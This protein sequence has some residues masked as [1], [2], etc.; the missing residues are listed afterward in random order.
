MN[1]QHER[2]LN[3]LQA[4]LAHAR[5]LAYQSGESKLS[6]LLD[7]LEIL[8]RYLADPH[9]CDEDFREMLAGIALKRPELRYVLDRFDAPPGADSTAPTAASRG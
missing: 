4:L 2:G 5:F 1:E 8:P 6:D 3:A 7:D 9:A